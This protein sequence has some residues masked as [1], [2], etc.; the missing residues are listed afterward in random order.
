MELP[1]GSQLSKDPAAE[2]QGKAWKDRSFFSG[3]AGRAWAE[4]ERGGVQR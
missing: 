3:E 1:S 2:A 4:E